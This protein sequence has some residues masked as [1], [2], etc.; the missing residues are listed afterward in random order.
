MVVELLPM[1]AHP[2]PIRIPLPGSKR[3]GRRRSSKVKNGSSGTKDGHRKPS[4][5]NSTFRSRSIPISNY[6]HRTDSELQLC[7]DEAIADYHDYCF[8]SRIIGGISRQQMKIK[9]DLELRYQ[10]DETLA[11]IIRTRHSPTETD[12][13]QKDRILHILNDANDDD[14]WAF[15]F[16]LDD[17]APAYEQEVFVLDM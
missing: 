1:M 16:V 7:E 15:D 8:Y 4:M 12:L 3:R 14:D 17:D 10:N 2:K 11:N 9:S 13:S 5:L 6:I